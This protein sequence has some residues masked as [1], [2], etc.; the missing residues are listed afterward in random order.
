MNLNFYTPRCAGGIYPAIYKV[1]QECARYLQIRRDKDAGLESYKGLYVM[2]RCDNHKLF[3]K[4]ECKDAF[5]G[6][7]EKHRVV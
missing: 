1:R 2:T 4:E 5:F 6:R 3:M 7:Y